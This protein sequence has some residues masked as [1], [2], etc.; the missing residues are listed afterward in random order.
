MN[1]GVPFAGNVFQDGEVRYC[2][3]RP[4]ITRGRQ[5]QR[6][7]KMSSALACLAPNLP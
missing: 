3:G 2:D 1:D 6:I 7:S 4:V 5:S